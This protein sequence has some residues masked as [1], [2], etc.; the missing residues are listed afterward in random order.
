MAGAFDD[1]GQY[2]ITVTNAGWLATWDL[3]TF[4]TINQVHL[5]NFTSLEDTLELK[6]LSDQNVVL[7]G[8]PKSNRLL[9]HKLDADMFK[10][11]EF[12]ESQFRIVTGMKDE[13]KN[14][15]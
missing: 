10:K 7:I 6:L 13:L 3:K 4:E 14:R 5:S 15:L 1:Q 2:F 11:P 12:I 8:L 9:Y